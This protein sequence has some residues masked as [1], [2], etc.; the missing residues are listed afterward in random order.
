M[1]NQ[2]G[3]DIN[4]NLPFPQIRLWRRESNIIF[5]ISK[6]SF[7][8]GDLNATSTVKLKLDAQSIR[9]GEGHDTSF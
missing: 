7:L 5:K 2:V 4:L 8:C 9:R 3:H 1:P 6:N